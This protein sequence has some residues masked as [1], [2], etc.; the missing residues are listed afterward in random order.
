MYGTIKID[1]LSL[2]WDRMPSVWVMSGYVKITL[3]YVNHYILFLLQF[4]CPPTWPSYFDQS[5]SMCTWMI[6]G[7]VNIWAQSKLKSNDRYIMFCL[8]L[9]NN[10][11]L[12]LLYFSRQIALT[13]Y[14]FVIYCHWPK[15]SF[16]WYSC[17][18]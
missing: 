15:Y 14:M 8:T 11:I 9:K 16:F 17:H 7:Y 2:G 1:N 13:G 3:S 6:Y 12:H 4:K 10:F 5:I 18:M